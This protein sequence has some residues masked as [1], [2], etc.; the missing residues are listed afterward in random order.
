MLAPYRADGGLLMLSD[1]QSVPSN[2]QVS[3]SSAPPKPDS[4]PKR[5]KDSALHLPALHPELPE[6]ALHAW[7]PVP[8][9]VSSVPST[10]CPAEQHPVHEVESQAHTLLMQ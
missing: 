2:V 3:L 4:P 5:T 10:H 1:F 7:P 6:H 8:H 9:A